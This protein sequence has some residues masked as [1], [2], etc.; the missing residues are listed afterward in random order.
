MKTISMPINPARLVHC[1]RF[2]P[3]LLLFWLASLPGSVQAQSD[4]F[5]R[6]ND[7]GWTRYD[8]LGGLGVGP[9]ATFTF[10]HGGYRMQ[11]T[12]DPLLPD[13][14]GPARAGTFRADATYSD[15]YVA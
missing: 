2:V 1:G 4:N 14:A 5:N 6:G 12:K 8:A 15:F 7:S 13:Q 11:A 10:P 9:Q 3:G